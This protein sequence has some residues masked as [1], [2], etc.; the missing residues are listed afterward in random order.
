MNDI[1]KKNVNENR[2]EENFDMNVRTEKIKAFE[3]YNELKSNIYKNDSDL[4]L[5]KEQTTDE[6]EIE[7]PAMN[8]DIDVETI[9]EDEEPNSG[10]INKEHE[11]AIENNE[12][13][14]LED[15]ENS[16]K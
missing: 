1:D 10:D 5:A 3:G 14:E 13:G 9:N 2:I 7:I 6:D 11:S 8:T 4:S 15:G 16:A 12:D